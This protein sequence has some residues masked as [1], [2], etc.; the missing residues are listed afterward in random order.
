[1]T[2]Q[3]GDKDNSAITVGD[4]NT[5]SV[6]EVTHRQKRTYRSESYTFEFECH[7]QITCSIWY[8]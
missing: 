6:T 2:V 4:I 3:K 7:C 5:L 8:L 1:M